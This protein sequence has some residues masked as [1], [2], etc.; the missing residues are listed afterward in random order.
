MRDPRIIHVVMYETNKS[1]NREHAKNMQCTG[2][3][4]R[5]GRALLFARGVLMRGAVLLL[6][7][8]AVAERLD[9]ALVSR[10]LCASRTLAKTAILAGHVVVNGVVVTKSAFVC[11]DDAELRVSCAAAGRFVSR[12]GEKLRAALDTFKVDVA[13]ATILD[14]GASTG[15]FTDCLLSAGAARAVCVDCGHGQLHPKLASDDRLLASIEGVNARHLKAEQLPLA[16]YETIVVDVSFISLLLVLPALW[17]LLDAASPRARLIALVKPQFEVGSQLGEEGRSALSKGKGVLG[18]LD[19]QLRVLEGVV[20]FAS[21]ELEGCNVVGSMESP[22][23][24]GDGN[25]EWLI[26]LA[27]ATHAPRR[28]PFVNPDALTSTLP[29]S[30]AQHGTELS[31]CASAQMLSDGAVLKPSRKATAASRA[32]LRQNQRR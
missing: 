2:N 29:T 32:A 28:G 4:R 9:A 14:V 24:G 13:G 8:T 15:G 27:R 31:D 7:A 20:D 16:S 26:A 19:L 22:I 10:G 25:R 30:N 21:N 17:P 11:D 23:T 5:R 12:S 1:R 3:P 18:D 6:C